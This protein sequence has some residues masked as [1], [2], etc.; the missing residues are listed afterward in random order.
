MVIWGYPELAAALGVI[1]S[2]ILTLK[3]TLHGL[4][5]RMSMADLR[6]ILEFAIITAVVLPILPNETYGPFDVLNPYEIWLFVV[7]V[8]AISFLGYILINILGARRGIG[9][10]GLL[11]GLVSS[12]AVTLSFAGRSKED[13]DLSPV[14]AIAIVLASSVMFPRVLVEVLVI[15]A[16]LLSQVGIPLIAMML[17]GLGMVY[18]LWRRQRVDSSEESRDVSL[19]NPLN[20]WSAITFGVGFALVLVVVRAGNEFLGDLGVYLASVLTG[21]VDVDA[22]TLSASDLAAK[23]QVT[24]QLASTSIMIGVLVNTFVKA[25][26]AYVL[27]SP[28]L[29]KYVIRAF[30]AILLVGIISTVLSLSLLL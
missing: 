12:T 5:R 6:A 18:I 15:Y 23:G 30:A 8:S 22:I 16:P 26:T 2:L 29:K 19:R 13:Q 27:G 20:I 3:N 14:F 7:L 21:L 24:R 11:G 10:T 25:V 9:V 17:T 28:R 4:A 1:T